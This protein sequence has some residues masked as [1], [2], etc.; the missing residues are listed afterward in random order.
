M[1]SVVVSGA[2]LPSKWSAGNFPKAKGF[3]RYRTIDTH[4]L[5]KTTEAN[6]SVLFDPIKEHA[7]GYII[8][9]IPGS[10]HDEVNNPTSHYSWY[11]VA[12]EQLMIAVRRRLGS[13]WQITTEPNYG[14]N[15]LVDGN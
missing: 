13:I 5:K 10:S 2:V 11:A 15:L 6:E 8:V 9:E 14:L 1:A 7:F 4:W 12:G 3:A